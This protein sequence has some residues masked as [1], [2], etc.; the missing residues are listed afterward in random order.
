MSDPS[1]SDPS[2]SAPPPAPPFESPSPLDVVPCNNKRCKIVDN[3]KTMRNCDAEGC[4]NNIHYPCYQVLLMKFNTEPLLETDDETGG[5]D[6]D[7]SEII[8]CSKRCY[9]KIRDKKEKKKKE[10][11]ATKRITWDNDTPDPAV[12]SH[13]IIIDWMTTASN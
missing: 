2:M 1:V 6:E 13:S 11:P 10:V 3:D 7:G 9:N 4:P 12:L 5:T 8:V